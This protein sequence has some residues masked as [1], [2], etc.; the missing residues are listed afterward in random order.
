[1]LIVYITRCRNIAFERIPKQLLVKTL[2]TL[3]LNVFLKGGLEVVDR[4]ADLE[5]HEAQQA[6][7]LSSCGHYKVR[8]ILLIF[9]YKI[10]C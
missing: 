4:I 10:S 9:E 6:T 7:F 1:M 3:L 2:F 5:T 8:I